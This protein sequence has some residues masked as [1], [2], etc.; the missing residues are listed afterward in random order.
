MRSNA[1]W[2]SVPGIEEESSGAAGALTAAKP[3]AARTASHSRTT[4]R[5]RPK[6]ARPSRYKKVAMEEELRI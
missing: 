3:I 4:Y 5:R 6:A 2:D 1:R